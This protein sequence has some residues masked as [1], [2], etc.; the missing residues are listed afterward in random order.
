MIQFLYLE[1]ITEE[2]RKNYGRNAEE[3]M[4]WMNAKPQITAAEIAS[5]INKSQS[6]I[7]KLI[8]KL[9]EKKIIERIGS[10]KG[11]YWKVVINNIQGHN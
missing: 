3:I 7:E 10:T 1:K 11:G 5:K 4:A 9:R 8:K 2:I 6:T